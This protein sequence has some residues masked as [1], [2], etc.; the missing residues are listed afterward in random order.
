MR[1]MEAKDQG[2]LA[3]QIRVHKGSTAGLHDN[4]IVAWFSPVR[5]TTSPNTIWS[6]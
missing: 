6:C 4:G 1:T 3:S 5:T 2:G